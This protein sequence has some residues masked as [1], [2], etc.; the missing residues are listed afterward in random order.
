M[1]KQDFQFELPDPQI[2]DHPCDNRTGSRLLIVNPNTK[3]LHDRHFYD[4]VDYLQPEDCL[5]F[6]NT[7]VIPA[8]LVGRRETGGK[9]EVLLERVLAQENTCIAQV[10]ASN[11]PKNGAQ[12]IITENFI[13]EVIGREGAFFKLKCITDLPL[14][15]QIERYGCMP[16]PPYIQRKAEEFDKQRYQTV[17][18]EKQG[19][20]AAPT[21]GLHFDQALLTKIKEKGLAHDFVTLHVGA[22]T[23]SPVRV[24]DIIDHKMHSEWFEVPESVV[25]L[26]KKTREKGGRV[27]CVGTTSVRCL[28]SA[29]ISGQLIASSGETDIFIYPGYQFQSV[30][31]LI[32]N[33]H[34][35]ESTLLMLVSA[36][37]GKEFILNAYKHAVDS[38]YRFFSYGDAMFIENKIN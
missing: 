8:R 30:D 19:A 3:G 31:A 17:Y 5:I 25:A 11:T 2:A 28:E 29:S 9:I 18:A 20:V 7:K 23:F 10:R 15:E 1:R 26:I 16:L 33:F 27:I 38:Q 4:L 13:L 32:T 37:A 6:N 14:A 35:S 34:L 12:I 21:A 24:D 36:F 22:G